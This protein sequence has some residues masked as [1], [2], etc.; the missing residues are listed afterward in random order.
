MSLKDK[1]VSMSAYFV[2]KGD[3]NYKDK[4]PRWI[5]CGENSF[6]AEDVKESILEF[7]DI[8]ERYGCG[9]YLTKFREIF[10]DFEE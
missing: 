3:I 6:Y 8:L 10:G 4:G 2:D 7:Q 9:Y 5:L 1:E